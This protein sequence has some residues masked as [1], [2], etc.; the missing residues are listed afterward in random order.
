MQFGKRAFDRPLL[1]L[2]ANAGCRYVIARDS[3]TREPWFVLIDR[4]GAMSGQPVDQFEM[5]PSTSPFK[6]WVACGRL[7]HG[8]RRVE[9][10]SAPSAT[11][12]RPAPECGSLACGGATRT[13]RVWSGS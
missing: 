5:G 12:R 8:T 4:D 11:T 6:T 9:I 10:H 13:S 2:R 1:A 7:P 3:M